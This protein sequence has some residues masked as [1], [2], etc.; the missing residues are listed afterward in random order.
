MRTAQQRLVG[1]VDI[2]T[3]QGTLDDFLAGLR[4]TWQAGGA[5]QSRQVANA[6]A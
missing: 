2:G 4:T 6:A 3:E 5:C 1:I